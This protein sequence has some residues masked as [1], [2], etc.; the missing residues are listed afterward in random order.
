[1]IIGVILGNGT[2]V[3]ALKVGQESQEI[4]RRGTK[5]PSRTFVIHRDDAE[6]TV[7]IHQGFGENCKERGDG[8]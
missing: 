1:M 3:I 8:G 2:L 7:T 4:T 5:D 6:E